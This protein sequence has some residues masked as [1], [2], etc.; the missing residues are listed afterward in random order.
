VLIKNKK[1]ENDSEKR[2]LQS[3]VLALESKLTSESNRVSS[4]KDTIDNTVEILSQST[5]WNK[6]TLI[7]KAILNLKTN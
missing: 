6:N 3:Q 1:M 2:R 4:L 7:K 5:L